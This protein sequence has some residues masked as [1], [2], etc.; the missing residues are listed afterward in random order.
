MNIIRKHRLEPTGY[1]PIIGYWYAK[2]IEAKTVRLLLSAKLGGL[3]PSTMETLI[4]PR[5]LSFV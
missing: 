3:P 5:Y 1:D 2:E 4:R